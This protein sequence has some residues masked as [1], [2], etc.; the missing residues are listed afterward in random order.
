ME[1]R[2]R[3][4]TTGGAALRFPD[5]AT[6][7]IGSTLMHDATVGDAALGQLEQAVR[8]P[9]RAPLRLFST[10]KRVLHRSTGLDLRTKLLHVCR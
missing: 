6:V 10:E 4:K 7:I 8:Q 5:T 9:P 3:A 1:V 2:A